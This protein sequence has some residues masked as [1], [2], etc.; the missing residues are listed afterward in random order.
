MSPCGLVTELAHALL[1]DRP[2]AEV[3][4]LDP[5]LSAQQAEHDLLSLRAWEG[6]DTEVEPVPARQ[7][8]GDL[9][10][11]REPALGDVDARE[12]LR[13]RQDLEADLDADALLLDHPTVDAETHL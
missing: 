6:R 1:G 8:V 13:P 9:A 4:E 2:H 5:V 7:L 3:G 11:L 10:V 12:H